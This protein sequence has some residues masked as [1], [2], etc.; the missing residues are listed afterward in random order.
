MPWII[1]V[2]NVVLQYK[3]RDIPI[4]MTTTVYAVK[5]LTYFVRIHSKTTCVFISEQQRAATQHLNSS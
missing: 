5:H 4:L 2:E 3:Y 1:K